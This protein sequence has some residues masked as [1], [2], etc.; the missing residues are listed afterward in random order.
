MQAA[1][2]VAHVAIR[3][4]RRRDRD[5]AIA[6]QQ[7]ADVAD[8]PDIDVAIFLRKPESLGEI[9]AD[10]VAIED[11]DAML[12]LAQFFGGQIRKR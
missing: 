5:H 12:A 8:P 4:N 2:F 6:R 11:F 3:R 1:H 10:F 9:G 7:I